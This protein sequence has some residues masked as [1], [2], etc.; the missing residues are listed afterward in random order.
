[1]ENKDNF[2]RKPFQKWFRSG[3]HSLLRETNAR[4]KR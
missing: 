3:I 1:M 2:T 4:K